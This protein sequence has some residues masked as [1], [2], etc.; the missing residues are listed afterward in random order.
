VLRQRAPSRSGH[1]EPQAVA[2]VSFRHS[3]EIAPSWR[4]IRPVPEELHVVLPSTT[5]RD[6][7]IFL[8]SFHRA[9]SD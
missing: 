8:D 6:C 9:G 4:L 7:P 2:Q 5:C 3:D 1:G